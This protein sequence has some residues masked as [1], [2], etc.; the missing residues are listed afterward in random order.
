MSG[1]SERSPRDTTVSHEAR[2]RT[3]G[4]TSLTDQLI[5]RHFQTSSFVAAAAYLIEQARQLCALSIHF[6][7]FGFHLYSVR[8]ITVNGYGTS[9]I[10]YEPHHDKT[11]KITCA[12]SKDS[13]QPGNQADL[14]LST[15]HMPLCWFCH[16]AAH[17]DQ[18]LLGKARTSL[19][20]LYH[21]NEHAI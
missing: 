18:D 2:V 16:D 20:L 21:E 1:G 12:P 6:G 4:V 7:C 3:C 17:I 13:D 19:L 11:N 14:S 15:A 8:S 5:R 10:P 9:L